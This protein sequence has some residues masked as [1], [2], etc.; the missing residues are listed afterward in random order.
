MSAYHAQFR[1]FFV[2]DILLPMITESNNLDKKISS[3]TDQAAKIFAEIM[4]ALLDEQTSLSGNHE[5][6]IKLPN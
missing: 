3:D 4:V 6:E 1:A 5:I 2:C